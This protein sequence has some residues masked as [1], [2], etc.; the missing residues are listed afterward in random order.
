M[1]SQRPQLLAKDVIDSSDAFLA[2][3]LTGEL[4]QD[5]IG[6]EA[7]SR[8]GKSLAAEIIASLPSMAKGEAWLIPDS[9]WLEG[10]CAEPLRFRF[11]WRHTFDSARP[12]RVGE[13]R[14]APVVLADVDLDNLRAAMA[15]DEQ[16]AVGEG[17]R[18]ASTE[19]L[20]AAERR[21]YERGRADYRAQLRDVPAR[22]RAIAS[23]I[24]GDPGIE[25]A[26]DLKSVSVVIE[27]ILPAG[28][29]ERVTPAPAAHKRPPPM[30][31]EPAAAGLTGPE[32]R[33]VDAI[34][35]MN[36]IGVAEPDQR[37]VGFVAGYSIDGSAYKSPR[38]A[39]R[40]KGLV[41]YLGDCIAL[42]DAGR[43]AARAP[44]SPAT[45]SELHLRVLA[46][47]PG[48]ETK[49]LTEVL[50]VYPN[51]ISNEDLGK[52]TGYSIDGSA[53]KSPRARLRTLGLVEYTAAGV[54]A[55]DFLFPKRVRT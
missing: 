45:R 19:E 34:A 50:A 35:W 53:F 43:K 29:P 49:L 4:A 17:A 40:T 32:Q 22:L 18:A 48:P 47:L 14:S 54:R 39:L 42:T 30:A 41:D 33:I 46:M 31:R 7:R 55:R 15:A 28:H 9:D 26:D 11:R 3:K 6:A 23:L 16:P 20:A 25:L 44:A 12:P 8:A 27:P 2:M 52:R 51:A 21:G 10:E 38:A 1:S 5:A 36:A 37:A 24:D 13:E